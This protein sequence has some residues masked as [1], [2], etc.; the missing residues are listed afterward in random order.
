[1]WDVL[2]DLGELC[3]L[4]LGI[5]GETLVALGRF[6]VLEV[7]ETVLKELKNIS[8]PFTDERTS[9]GYFLSSLAVALVIYTLWARRKN[10]TLS[11]RGAFQFIFPKHIWQHPFAWLDLRYFFITRLSTVLIVA[12]IGV[13]VGTH[14][15]IW[16]HQAFS[17]LTPSPLFPSVS[18][19]ALFLSLIALLLAMSA[20]FLAFLVHR[21]QH[22]IPFLWEFHKVHHS[23]L[24]LQPLSS[25]REHFVD[26]LLYFL[27]FQMILSVYTAL[28]TAL[29]GYHPTLPT[30]LGVEAAGFL[31]NFIAYHLRH[32]HIWLAY[33]PYWLGYLF[34]SPAHH[35]IHHSKEARHIDKNFGF[36]FSL[37]DW[38][39]GT[40]YLPREREKFRIGLSDNSEYDYSTIWRILW[41]PFAKAFKLVPQ[42]LETPLKTQHPAQ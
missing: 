31:Y 13:Y 11:L 12:P 36:M 39:F 30:I 37:W 40:L 9:Y 17:T 25:Y 26:D 20:D 32:S 3:S 19:N 6:L 21:L 38:A 4:L 7:W 5:I 28:A 33:K 8:T 23:A 10:K 35:Q 18:F 1:M 22:K 27:V 2:I 34:I 41:V 42:N 24:V 15:F 16:A 29:L 14:T